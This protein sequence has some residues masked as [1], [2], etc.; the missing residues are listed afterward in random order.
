MT[1]QKTLL[2]FAL[3]AA[4]I[5]VPLAFG[6]SADATTRTTRTSYID[7]V[8]TVNNS[9]EPILST[10]D[11]VGSYTMGKSQMVLGL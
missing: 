7:L 1:S 3:F 10:N 11:A 8:D 2:A 9:I 6:N 5:S 4:M